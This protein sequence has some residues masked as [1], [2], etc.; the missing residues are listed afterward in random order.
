[1]TPNILKEELT[2][3]T[4]GRHYVG[5]IEQELQVSIK[6]ILRYESFDFY[7]KNVLERSNNQ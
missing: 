4:T 3:M 2:E 5:S 1:M 6:Q 7:R